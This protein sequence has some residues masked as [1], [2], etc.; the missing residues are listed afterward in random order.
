MELGDKLKSLRKE[1]NYSQNQLADKLYVTAQAISKWENNQ[2]V[3]DI[4]NLISLSDLYNVSLDYLIKSDKELQSKLSISNIHLK[5]F[6]WFVFSIILSIMFLIIILAK[7]QFFM[8]Q[9]GIGTWLFM[10]C[11]LLFILSIFLSLYFYIV[12]KDHFIFL[13]IALLMVSAIIFLSIFYDYIMAVL[14]F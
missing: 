12:K 13:W 3:P 14:F 7:A 2:S 6:K 1:H 4:I 8:F 10:G 9:H 11:I 5:I